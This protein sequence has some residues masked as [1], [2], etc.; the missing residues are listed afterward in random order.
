MHG[1]LIRGWVL[2]K[3][4]GQEKWRFRHGRQR[5]GKT[6]RN[7]DTERCSERD[8]DRG[9]HGKRD[10]EETKKETDTSG[11]MWKDREMHTDKTQIRE[12]WRDKESC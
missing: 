3:D 10:I 12:T 1:P 6:E 11:R 8:K 5:H 4:L 9:E 2:G 7:G